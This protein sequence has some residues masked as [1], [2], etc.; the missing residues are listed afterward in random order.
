M[1]CPTCDGPAIPFSVPGDLREFAPGETR[2]VAICVRCLEL[3]S[4][5][6]PPAETPDFS[7]IASDFPDGE[8]G[9][10]MVLAVG[11]LVDSL[12]LHRAEV[13]ALFERVQDEGVDPWL[14]LERLARAGSVDP[15]A[16]LD[17]LRRQLDQLLR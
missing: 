17:R 2:A 13:T 14:V 4:A 11:L 3:A 10:A 8:A 12:V 15:D 6:E 7:R 16:D 1:D 5:D 9:A